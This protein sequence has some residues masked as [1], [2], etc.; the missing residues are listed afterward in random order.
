MLVQ[1]W[2]DTWMRSAVNRELFVSNNVLFL[3][4]VLVDLS[5]LR[6]E[7][8][9]FDEHAGL[10]IL[11]PQKRGSWGAFAFHLNLTLKALHRT[12]L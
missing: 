8:N 10:R 12:H 3:G 5:L 11:F 4:Q 7:I 2:F 9:V 6:T 1:L